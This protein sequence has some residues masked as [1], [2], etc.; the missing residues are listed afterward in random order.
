MKVRVGKLVPPIIGLA[1]TAAIVYGLL[2]RPIEVDAARVR[3]G[4]MRVT[5]DEDGKTRVKERYVVSV[6]L[7]GRLLRIGLHAG[8]PVERGKT[9]I[10]AIE[11][12]EPELLDARAVAQAEARVK[13][14]EAAK[15]RAGPL[16]DSARARHEIAETT[17]ARLRQLGDKGSVTR[18]EVDDAEHRL[19]V[20]TEDARAAK[21]A[22]QVAAFELEQARAALIRSRPGGGDSSAGRFEIRSP[23]GGRVLR[24]FQES[25]AAVAVG[26]RLVELGDPA[27]LECE[28]DVLSTDAVKIRPGT[29]AILENWGGDA[30]LEGRVR[31]VE[32][33]A[34][35]KVSA[36]GVEEQRVNVLIDFVGPLDQR[37][38]LGDGY[39]LD[40]RI[41]VWEGRDVLEVSTGAL[42]RRG[43][44]WAVFAVVA[45]KARLHRV[46]IGRNNGLDAEV[47][48]GLA[49]GD[50]VILHP[51]DKI[52]DGTR[53]VP[54][55]E[56]DQGS[57]PPIVPAG[58]PDGS[59][60]G[61]AGLPPGG[62]SQKSLSPLRTTSS[63]L[64]S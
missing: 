4:S 6:P 61:P 34:F 26:A 58:L 55:P 24:V 60:T 23:I 5:V 10:A 13:A 54:R 52:D 36:L 9:V 38:A 39:R 7:A 32:P 1:V 12:N 47:L 15:E 3:R 45:G 28:I 27:D 8:D 46:R 21:F 20:A 31:L 57:A 51:S 64:P 14:A 30:S 49:E 22:A 50:R 2:P 37:E 43:A 48:D 53:I 44:D 63:V 62:E 35:T 16:V 19:R 41:V 18:Q 29:R 42:F 25:A 11:P 33:A 40:A 17:F 59:P 56:G